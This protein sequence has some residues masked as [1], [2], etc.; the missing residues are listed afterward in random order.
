MS[1]D[2]DHRWTM[3]EARRFDTVDPF[4]DE[5]ERCAEIVVGRL[6]L[7]GTALSS[8]GS[9]RLLHGVSPAAPLQSTGACCDP[10]APC[11]DCTE[12]DQLEETQ[13]QTMFNRIEGGNA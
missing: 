11:D 8:Y 6:P 5:E 1:S 12:I 13:A 7:R 3:P 10:F 4:Y 9:S 2:R